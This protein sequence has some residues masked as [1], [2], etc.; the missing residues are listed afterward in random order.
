MGSIEWDGVLQT[1][2]AAPPIG[3]AFAGACSLRGAHRLLVNAVR[4][5]KWDGGGLKLGVDR[6]VRGQ[7]FRLVGSE[8]Y[9]DFFA[10]TICKR[11]S[12]D[13]AYAACVIHEWKHARINPPN[14]ALSGTCQG[15]DAFL[16]VKC[17]DLITGRD[18]RDRVPM[19]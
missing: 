12:S 17:S 6:S 18:V 16:H 4:G 13:Q 8:I 11:M 14:G 5:H 9:P 3:V 10:P 1:L 15:Y 19:K 2:A 7:S